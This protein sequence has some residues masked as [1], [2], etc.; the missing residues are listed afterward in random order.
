MD[1]RVSDVSIDRSQRSTQA[2]PE[3]PQPSR[4]LSTSKR[5]ASGSTVSNQETVET[6]ISG[7]AGLRSDSSKQPLPNSQSPE[8]QLIIKF[9]PDASSTQ[10]DRLKTALEATTV[11]TAS[12]QQI[13]LWELSAISVEDAVSTY[14]NA[15]IIEYM[16][17]NLP[18]YAG[19]SVPSD[20]QFGEQW[21]LNNTGQTGGTPDADIDAPAAWNIRT[22]TQKILIGV[23]DSGV[24]YNHPDLKDNLWINPGEIADNGKDD[25]GNGYVDDVYGYDFANNDGDPF[26]DDS[27]GHGT[28]VT[29]TIAARGNNAAGVTGV[30][31]NARIASIKF[32]DENGVGTT[33][34]A[35]KAIEY[36]S[37]IGVDLSNHSWEEGG[38]AP[39]LRDAIATAGKQGQLTI[40]SAGNTASD[41]DR[42]PAYPSSYNLDSV[43]SVAATNDRDE[44]AGF[45]NFGAQSVDLAAPGVDILSTLPGNSYGLLSGTS[46]AAPHVTGVVS[47]LLA[48]FPDL[49]PAEIKQILLNSVDPIP[50]LADKTVSGGRLNAYKALLGL[51]AAEIRGSKWD[52]RDGDGVRDANE[53]GLANDIIYI[54]AN[55]NG[56]LDDG[57]LSTI[58]DKNGN[59]T[60]FVAP[61]TYSVAG[62]VRPGWEE[63]TPTQGRYSI[64][65]DK[66]ET[67]RGIDFGNALVDPGQISGVKWRDR[68]RDGIR[69]ANER[70]LKGWQIYLDLNR[71]GQL[72]KDEPSRLTSANGRYR[73]K[74]LV[75]GEYVVA[76]VRRLGWKQTSP[77]T[78]T[79]GT[80][81]IE[82]SD[83]AIDDATDS[84]LSSATPGRVTISSTIGNNPDV[85]DEADVDMVEIQLN[86]GD[87]VTID[88]DTSTGASLDSALRLFD[89]S[90]QELAINDDGTAPGEQASRDSYID[91]TARTTDSYFV[92]VSSYSNIFYDPF[93]GGDEN[94]GFSSGD[95]ELEI[96]LGSEVLPGTYQIDLAP[97]ER[98]NRLDFGNDQL[99]TGEISGVHWNDR[100]GNGKRD[101]G[102]P[103]LKGRTVFIDR[104]QNGRL[105]PS[106]QS[107]VTDAKG[108]YVLKDAPAGELTVATVV[109]DGW[110]QTQPTAVEYTATTSNQSGGPTFDWIEISELGTAVDL[111]DDDDI[112]VSLPFEFSFFGQSKD[113]IRISSN[114]YLTFS[115]AAT[116]FENREVGTA[117][118]PNDFIAP[119]WDDLDPEADGSVFY[120]YDRT[121]R[122][123]IVQ[124]QDVPRQNEEGALTFQVILNAD[125]SIRYQYKKMAGSADSATIGVE[126]VDGTDGLQIAFNEPYAS[127]GLAVD[128]VG[129]QQPQPYSVEVSP[130]EI[131]TGLD[132]GSQKR[133][134]DVSPSAEL[135]IGLY[136]ADRDRLIAVIEDGAEISVT[137][138]ARRNLTIAARIP[139]TSTLFK[140]VE[141]AFI[142]LND[143]RVTRTENAATY[144][145]FGDFRDNLFSGKGIQTG[146]NSISFELYSKDGL[147]GEQLATVTRQF[148]LVEDS[149]V[150]IGLYDADRDRLI[151]TLQDGVEILASEL[152]GRNVT[153]AALVPED[154]PLLDAAESMQLNFNEGEVVRAENTE[155]YALFGDREGDFFAGS[156]LPTGS[157]TLAVDVYSG[158]DLQ[159]QLLETVNRSFTIVND[160][161]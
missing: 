47:L 126:N 123:F 40:A 102:E 84:N 72:N 141:S 5:A 30:N 107:A 74:N 28:H 113:T 32:L 12:S 86:A 101:A 6:E 45:S 151:R 59:Y 144:S 90:G 39:A 18:I 8:D 109:P 69:Q 128:I 112:E 134:P 105:E 160:L 88:V 67:V 114:G 148:T 38:F 129:K 54:D 68:N 4:L 36:A 93:M 49:S 111:L 57:E 150:D 146:R 64:A 31:W 99:P 48:E 51:D 35:I 78:G 76:E 82:E 71:N 133:T 56:S 34:N 154:S 14:G 29:G 55:N 153:I 136:D 81:D 97:G 106:E 156:G 122:Q 119:F 137:D 50:E 98:A 26:D 1:A 24:D 17:P 124:Y 37:A 138:L 115:N 139:A 77:V 61:G 118:G 25:D 43:I 120:Y 92:A 95:Y 52:D 27:E 159:G 73:F 79:S 60:L 104:N 80:L 130:K 140:Q 46:M 13:Q 22:G 42:D 100:N 3:L 157:N 91:F 11:D 158:N 20:K 125:G 65:V 94:E 63:T 2:S 96:V 15:S 149:P 9:R 135:E 87:R 19:D 161:K 66:R 85:S 155:P 131:V 116:V 33:F 103:G 75:P 58:T 132:F 147:R 142:D 83:D 110:K 121:E 53:A 41:T 127:D 117:L 143:G 7:S 16:G 10:I 145:L 70:T 44:L 23:I 62:V 21:G 152:E 108:R 89:S